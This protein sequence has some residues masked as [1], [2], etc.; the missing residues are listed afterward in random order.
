M[1]QKIKIIGIDPGSVGVGICLLEGGTYMGSTQIDV[2]KESGDFYTRLREVRSKVSCELQRLGEADY[3]AI[4]MPWVGFNANVAIKL[5]Q[6]RGMIVGQILEYYPKA[7][8]IDIT[9]MQI[10]AFLNIERKCKKAEMHEELDRIF[11][12]NLRPV[13]VLGKNQDELDSIG[14]A[15]AAYNKLMIK[16]LGVRSNENLCLH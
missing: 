16:N 3:Y 12:G 15:I 7:Q 4:E 6:V 13:I 8:I 14:I 9:P 5:G 10:R 2:K 11:Q 1:T